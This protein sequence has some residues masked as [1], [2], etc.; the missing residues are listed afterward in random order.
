MD[1]DENED[2]PFS[3]PLGPAAQHL[4]NHPTPSTNKQLHVQSF[5]S[6]CSLLDTDS[7]RVWRIVFDIYHA[8]QPQLW[9]TYNIQMLL[10]QLFD[11]K[12]CSKT[13]SGTM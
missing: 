12:L 7:D 10:D 3:N 6:C 8:Y 1:T 5:C 11:T 4:L 13:A 9:V 2:Y